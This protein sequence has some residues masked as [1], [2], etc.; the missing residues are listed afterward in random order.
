[1][2]SFVFYVSLFVNNNPTQNPIDL[3]SIIT[4]HLT[5]ILNPDH[6]KVDSFDCSAVFFSYYHE[7][8]LIFGP[9]IVYFTNETDATLAK[10]LLGVENS[11]SS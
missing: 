2:F 4:K 7:R 1:M 6:I 10:E 11:F 8:V 9:I 5:V 3:K